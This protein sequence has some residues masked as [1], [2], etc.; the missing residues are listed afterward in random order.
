MRVSLILKITNGT[1]TVTRGS[2][3]P[4]AA[5]LSTIT[6]NKTHQNSIVQVTRWI[7][8]KLPS[9]LYSNLT[10]NVLL[11][12]YGHVF[13]RAAFWTKV[14]WG[15]KKKKKKKT[16]KSSRGWEKQKETQW[17][18]S[19]SWPT[20]MVKQSSWAELPPWRPSTDSGNGEPRKTLTAAARLLFFILN[21]F[22][23]SYCWRVFVTKISVWTCSSHLHRITLLGNDLFVHDTT[24]DV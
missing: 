1:T 16:V 8:N 15:E 14:V 22:R 2:L 10:I 17:E 4:E 21:T 13:S 7:R 23:V 5:C 11:K 24:C 9:W 3:P 18:L 6:L 12:T 20:R 19:S